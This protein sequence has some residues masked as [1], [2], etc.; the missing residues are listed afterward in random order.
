MNKI[1]ITSILSLTLIS[2]AHAQANPASL[3]VGLSI[4]EALLATGLSGNSAQLIA[5][6]ARATALMA[7]SATRIAAGAVTFVRSPTMLAI[8]GMFIVGALLT[9]STPNGPSI[10]MNND[11]TVTTTR[12]RLVDD[13][14]TTGPAFTSGDL[15]YCNHGSL[16]YPSLGPFFKSA[17]AWLG[18]RDGAQTYLGPGIYKVDNCNI[19]GSN[20]FCDITNTTTGGQYLYNPPYNAY[21]VGFSYTTPNGISCP[22]DSFLDYNGQCASLTPPPPNPN[23]PPQAG[24]PETKT[25]SFESAI[26]DLTSDEKNQIVSPSTIANIANAIGTQL[27]QDPTYNGPPIPI[28]T[29]E[30][31]IK[32]NGGNANNLPTIGQIT[33]PISKPEEEIIYNPLNPPSPQAGTGPVTGTL[34]GTGSTVQPGES[35][36][37]PDA[38]PVDLGTDPGIGI[39][40]PTLESTPTANAI[41]SPLMNIMPDIKSLKI[42]G[43]GGSCPT[44]EFNVFGRVMKLDSQCVLLEQNRTAIQAIMLVMFGLISVRIILEA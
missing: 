11:G 34:P 28:I 16:C 22:K 30:H 7:S 20:I 42:N 19:R 40:N 23:D 26:Q 44:P 5:A 13:G 43:K 33:Q 4:R 1:I 3:A 17:A 35:T 27:N 24:T 37:N 36:T 38:Q 39:P 10:S 32:G 18:Q 21:S 12:Y 9:S 25:H 41:L 14:S 8:G 31:V 2:N 29:N 6:Q 15:L